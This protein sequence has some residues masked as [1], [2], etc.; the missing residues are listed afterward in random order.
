MD[1]EGADSAVGVM[2]VSPPAKGFGIVNRLVDGYYTGG[3]PIFQGPGSVFGS[4]PKQKERKAGPPPLIR[5]DGGV[6]EWPNRRGPLFRW[7]RRGGS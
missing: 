3:G 5:A 7:R 4:G 6:M 2:G 1:D